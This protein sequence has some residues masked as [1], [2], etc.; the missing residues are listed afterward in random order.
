MGRKGGGER[1]RGDGERGE[2]RGEGD[3][4]DGERARERV[5]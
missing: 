4:G 1:Y 3:R 5:D 2:K